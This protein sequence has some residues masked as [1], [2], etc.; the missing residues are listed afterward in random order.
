[1]APQGRGAVHGPER[2]PEDRR[3]RPRIYGER[4][5]DPGKRVGQRRGWTIWVFD[6]HW[7]KKTKRYKT[8]PATWQPADGAIRV[9]LVDEWTGGRA[10]FCTAPMTSV[11]DSLGA[12]AD[13]FSLEN[14]FR[15]CKQVIGAGQQQVQFLWASIGTFHHR[16]RACRETRVRFRQNRKTLEWFQE[17]LVLE[18]AGSVTH[19]SR[20][21]R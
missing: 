16:C 20:C 12:V 19:G 4:R 6:L 21:I 1:M 3:G 2:H 7:E 8:F 9:V 18:T 15:D 11:A 10:C 5:I 13:R 17:K 14:A